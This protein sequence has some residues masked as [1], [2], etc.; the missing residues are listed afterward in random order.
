M[1][2]SSRMDLLES[3]LRTANAESF[4]E[5]FKEHGIDTATLSLLIDE[6]LQ[7]LGIEDAN[8]RQDILKRIENLHFPKE[9]VVTVKK[10]F[11]K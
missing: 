6:D 7:L 8:V 1:L 2:V 3:V 11:K 4:T 5:T 9:Y 10:N